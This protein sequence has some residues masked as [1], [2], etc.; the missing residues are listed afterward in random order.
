MQMAIETKGIKELED[1]LKRLE[2]KS[3]KKIVRRGVRAGSKVIQQEQKSNA[4]SMVG[5]TMGSLIS[6]ALAIRSPKQ[7][8]GSY[9]LRVMLKPNDEFVYV[10]KSGT[11]HFI[12]VAIEYGH[13][14]PGQGGSGAADVMPIPFARTALDTK[15][16]EALKITHKTIAKDI[17][18]EFNK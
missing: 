10:T 16:R 12:P 11:R 8:R 9:A 7:R 3:A 14:Y 6:K 1:K 5:G 4:T 2:L 13:A 15:R 17:E 18:T